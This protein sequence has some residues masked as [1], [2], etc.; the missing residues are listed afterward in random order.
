M[1]YKI[2]KKKYNIFFELYLL[3]EYHLV[4]KYFHEKG[5]KARARVMVI[6]V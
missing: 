6:R 2:K 3:M 5:W 1:K 4:E